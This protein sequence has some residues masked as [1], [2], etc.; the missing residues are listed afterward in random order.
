[1]YIEILILFIV[2]DCSI[3]WLLITNF[4]HWSISI[5]P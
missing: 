3:P 4:R 1:M 2:D 5:K